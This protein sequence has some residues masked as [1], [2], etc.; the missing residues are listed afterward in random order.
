MLDKYG[1]PIEE[2]NSENT[3]SESEK[4]LIDFDEPASKGKTKKGKKK[5]KKLMKKLKMKKKKQKKLEA[6]LSI[7]E[8]TIKEMQNGAFRDSLYDIAACDSEQ[9]RK[10][11]IELLLKKEGQKK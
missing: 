9:E 1:H 3:K 6:R 8:K 7:V 10:R 2:E 11:M 4:K 5:E